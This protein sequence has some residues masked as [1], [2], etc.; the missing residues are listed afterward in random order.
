MKENIV[1]DKLLELEL[2]SRPV[3]RVERTHL[4]D[5]ADKSS[6]DV[7]VQYSEQWHVMGA[8]FLMLT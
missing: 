6:A 5:W 8:H 7:T 1:V 4:L 2:D 3:R